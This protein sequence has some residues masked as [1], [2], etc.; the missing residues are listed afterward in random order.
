[1]CYELMKNRLA[2]LR[3]KRKGFFVETYREDTLLGV[4]ALQV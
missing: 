2:K 1:M 3:R 4:A